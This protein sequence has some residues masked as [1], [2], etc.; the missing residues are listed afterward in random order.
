MKEQMGYGAG[1]S[2]GDMA[3]KVKDYQKPEADFAERGFSKTD[4]YIERRDRF[5][6]KEAKMIK[7]Q[8]YEGRYS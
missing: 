1:K 8:H 6:G 4:A 5:E 3:P 7:K 2:Q